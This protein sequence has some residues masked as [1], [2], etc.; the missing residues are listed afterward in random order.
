MAIR[1]MGVGG[2][3]DSEK[4][5]TNPQPRKPIPFRTMK[6]HLII[7]SRGSKLA[8]W[9]AEREGRLLPGATVALAAFGA[10]FVWAAGVIGWK[11]RALVCA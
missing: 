5:F 2:S 9:Q 6:D 11:E 3:G 4:V 10:G 7:G 1:G 8:L